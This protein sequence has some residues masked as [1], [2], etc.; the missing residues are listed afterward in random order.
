M[1]DNPGKPSSP[2]MPTIPSAVPHSPSSCRPAQVPIKVF[3][4]LLVAWYCTQPPP[5]TTS[6]SLGSQLVPLHPPPRPPPPARAHDEQAYTWYE[7][8]GAYCAPSGRQVFFSM[9]GSSRKDFHSRRCVCVGP[10][11]SSFPRARL[12]KSHLIGSTNSL[13]SA[14][15]NV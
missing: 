6:P 3:P 1:A 12:L 5:M 9:R 8:A 10:N 7:L 11:L 2:S 4:I 13:M 15:S 14:A